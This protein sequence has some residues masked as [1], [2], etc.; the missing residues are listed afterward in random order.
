M[1]KRE[2]NKAVSDAKGETAEALKT[3]LDNITNKGQKKKLLKNAVV[4]ELL[5]RY[6]VEYEV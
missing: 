6:G 3:M 5:D 2:L 4:I 1:K